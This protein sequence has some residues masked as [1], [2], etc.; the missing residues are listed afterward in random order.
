[1]ISSRRV[2]LAVPTK[3]E[4]TMRSTLTLSA[5]AIIIMLFS[6]RRDAI[7]SPKPQSTPKLKRIVTKDSA[8]NITATA[9]YNEWELS[10]GDSVFSNGI[11]SAWTSNEYNSK[12]KRTKSF[13]YIPSITA[14][15][16]HWMYI[17]EYKD[18]TIPV[19]SRTYLHGSQTL[20][21]KHFYNAS[22]QL[23][24]D[25]NYH[26]AVGASFSTPYTYIYTYDAQGRL[27]TNTRLDEKK[28]S[29]NHI[30]YSYSTNHIEVLSISFTPYG[31]YS[32]L[33]VTDYT[34]SGRILSQK[35]YSSLNQL[36]TQTDYAYTFDTKGN[37]IKTISTD[38]SGNTR[39]SRFTVNTFGRPDKE[40]RFY[41]NKPTITLFYY[42]E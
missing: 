5:I 1:M 33:G 10:V 29:V 22:K 12:G 18:D 2:I 27:L 11:L 41:Q 40:E 23:V 26:T 28:D 4:L 8:G 20:L 36:L 42:Y 21:T 9:S 31:R 32:T 16:Y 39:E 30:A 24:L 35:T 34:S 3:H 38:L 15:G 14:V 17:D 6:C 25:S 7:D 19:L 37:V 13:L